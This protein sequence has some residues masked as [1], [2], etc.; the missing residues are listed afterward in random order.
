MTANERQTLPGV[1]EARSR[2]LLAGAIVAE[3][4]MELLD[5]DELVICPWAMREGIILQR[6]DGLAT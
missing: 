1:S 6:I 2:Q 3:A 5:L 4:S